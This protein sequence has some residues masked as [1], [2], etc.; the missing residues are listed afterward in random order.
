MILYLYLFVFTSYFYFI[1]HIFIWT[2]IA[3]L[4]HLTCAPP[5]SASDRRLC[6]C[7]CNCPHTLGDWSVADEDHEL[8]HIHWLQHLTWAPLSQIQRRISGVHYLIQEIV[9][10]IFNLTIP[11]SF[12]ILTL[13]IWIVVRRP[14]FCTLL[15]LVIC[16]SLANHLPG[17][18]CQESV[19]GLLIWANYTPSITAVDGDSMHIGPSKSSFDFKAENEK[20]VPVQV[21]R[22]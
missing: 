20:L 8:M 13:L 19:V 9:Q 3:D 14:A 15:R 2:T 12:G 5:R 6:G 22:S 1:K 21:I 10:K 4:D 17:S 11:Y 18:R 7:R 16:W